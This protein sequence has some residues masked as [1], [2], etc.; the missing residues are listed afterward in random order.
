MKPDLYMNIVL[1]LIALGLWAILLKPV[2]VS[3]NVV[4]STGIIDVNI[5]QID[6]KRASSVLDVNI[7]K[8]NGRM[9]SGSSVPVSIR[10]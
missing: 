1:T 5:K 8:I 6:G 9:F 2:F 7:E 3:E 10:K 4:A